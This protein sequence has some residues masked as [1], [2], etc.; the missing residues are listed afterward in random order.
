MEATMETIDVLVHF[1]SDGRATP[2]RF[3]WRGAEYLVDSTGRR[4][5]D[6][7]GQHILVMIPGGRAF[8]LLF[9]PAESLWYLSPI[10]SPSSLA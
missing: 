4:W 10:G 2:V 1:D 7:D 5:E 8:E 9:A 6:Q 3:N